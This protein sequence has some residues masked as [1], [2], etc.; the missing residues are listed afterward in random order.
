[1]NHEPKCVITDQC[2][3]ISKALD[4]VWK[5]VPH[6]YCMWHI[7]IKMSLKF[8]KLLNFQFINVDFL[9]GILII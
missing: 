1:M 2:R 8:F 6:Q 5:D 9:L 7:M 3:I 4:D